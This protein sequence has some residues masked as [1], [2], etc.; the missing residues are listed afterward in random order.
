MTKFAPNNILTSLIDDWAPYYVERTRA[1][2]EGKWQ[3]QDVFDG[4]AKGK[5]KMGPYINMPDD[6]KAMAL[7]TEAG[8]K[9]GTIDPFKCPV[10]AQDGKTVECKGGD[11]LSNEQIFGMNFYVQGIEGTIPK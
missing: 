10:V 4:L 1:M 3:S 6:V 11:R 8:I 9:A 2:L 7:A 5:V